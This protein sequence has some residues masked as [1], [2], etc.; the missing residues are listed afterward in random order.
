MGIDITLERFLQNGYYY[1]IT[2]SL[3]DSKFKGDDGVEH[4]TRF[5]TNYVINLLYGKEWLHG[6]KKNKI[7]GLNLKVNF[8][9]GKRITPVNQE[10]SA[11]E[12]DVVYYNSELFKDKESNKFLVNVTINYRINKKKHA[13]VWSL[14]MMNIFVAKESYGYF[15]NYKSGQVEP[16]ELAVPTP[17]LSY[18]I[19]F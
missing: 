9:G 8:F 15:Y 6:K 3:F 12:E 17:N 16:W 18:K 4:S 5:N 2:A 14:Q 1:L 11:I 10:Q 7:L 13:S 19:Q